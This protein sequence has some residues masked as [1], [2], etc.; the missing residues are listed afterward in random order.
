MAVSYRDMAPADYEAVSRLWRR[1]EGIR[2]G[3]ADSYEAICRYLDRNPGLSCVAEDETGVVGAV[4]CGHDGRRAHLN[5]LAVSQSHRRQGVGTAL[6]SWCLDRLSSVGV[7]LVYL[8]IM[9]DNL[10]AE[11]F[12]RELQWRPY[13]EVFEK[14]KL[15][16]RKV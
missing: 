10:V 4:L 12:W 14:V 16:C 6:A 2:L 15:L 3:D 5:H 8:S 1:T 11:C 9:E 7:T 13:A